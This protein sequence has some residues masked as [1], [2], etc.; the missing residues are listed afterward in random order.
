MKDQAH[1]RMCGKFFSSSPQHQCRF[2]A[3]LTIWFIDILTCIHTGWRLFDISR[4]LP[5]ER[6]DRTFG[7]SSAFLVVLKWADNSYRLKK[8]SNASMNWTNFLPSWEG[9]NKS[10]NCAFVFDLRFATWHL[11]ISLYSLIFSAVFRRLRQ[12]CSWWWLDWN[13]PKL[14]KQFEGVLLGNK[15]HPKKLW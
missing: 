7:N 8:T 15:C 5:E 12:G 6:Q 9:K 1:R 13:F 2:L 4:P 11:P 14:S 3:S 10:K